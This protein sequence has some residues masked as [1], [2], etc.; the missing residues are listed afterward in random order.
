[1]GPNQRVIPTASTDPHRRLSWLRHPPREDPVRLPAALAHAD[2]APKPPG[3]RGGV[4]F[5]IEGDRWIVTLG[6]IGRDYPP[7]D[8]DGF[9][10]FARSL[11]SPLLHESIRDAEPLSPI[12]ADRR[13]DNQWRHFESLSH[14]PERFAVV[15]TLPVPSTRSTGRG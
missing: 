11:P 12:Y 14:Y 5:P 15:A 6:G 10:E 2:P 1:V 7:T 13:T 8:E 3:T 4:I 9:L